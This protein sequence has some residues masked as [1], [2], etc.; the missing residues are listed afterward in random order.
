MVKR[1]VTQAALGKGYEGLRRLQYIAHIASL[2]QLIVVMVAAG[3]LL[4]SVQPLW[5]KYPSGASTV[6]LCALLAHLLVGL[7]FLV[8]SRRSSSS[9]PLLKNK[10]APIEYWG[11]YCTL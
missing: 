1:I 7:S 9:N 11:K 3:L 4:G 10:E 2:G 8:Y 5:D 6:V